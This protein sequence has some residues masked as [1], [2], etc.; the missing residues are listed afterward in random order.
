MDLQELLYLLFGVIFVL[1]ILVDI[2]LYL[3]S[4]KISIN[5]EKTKNEL[6][7]LTKTLDKMRKR[8]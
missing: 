5:L 6:K 8:I 1:I 3:Q 7:E 4:R 2:H